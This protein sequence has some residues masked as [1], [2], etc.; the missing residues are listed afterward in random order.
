[1]PASN[2]R[3][4]R[5]RWIERASPTPSMASPSILRPLLLPR[6]ASEEMGGPHLGV[7]GTTE[8]RYCEP[9]PRGRLHQRPRLRPELATRSR[10]DHPGR[11]SRPRVAG[12]LRRGLPE[13]ALHAPGAADAQMRPEESEPSVPRSPCVA[14]A[15]RSRAPATRS[16]R[17][18][19]TNRRSATTS[20]VRRDD[21]DAAWYP[22]LPTCRRPRRTPAPAARPPPRE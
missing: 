4:T 2:S 20:P 19:A 12:A 16:E 9:T 15:P 3:H 22:T 5:G 7:S 18:P 10:S 17:R 11:R 14:S 8:F 6:V 13:G 21:D 1:M